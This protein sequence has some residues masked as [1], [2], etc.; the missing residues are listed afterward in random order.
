MQLAHL[1][2][3]S[4]GAPSP[5]KD[6]SPM[7]PLLL[8]LLPVL[9]MTAALLCLPA[10][11]RGL[12]D[13][14]HTVW[15]HQDG[16]PSDIHGLAQ[17]TDGWLW[18]GG[19]DGLFRF[20]GVGFERYAPAGH[21]A[22]VHMPVIE[23][24]AADNGDLYVAYFPQDVG[25]IRRDG[26]FELLPAP[27][28]FRRTQPLAMVV[29]RDG[30]LWTIGA[31]VRRYANGQWTTLDAS[32]P[33]MHDAFYSMLLDQEGRLW[34]AG[35]DGAY[36][37]DRARGRFE[38]VSALH[39]GLAIR[40][41]GDVWLLGAYGGPSVRLAEAGAVKARP[42]RIGAVVSR[43]AGQF[44][45]DG[46]LWA[47][48]CP[49]KIC[50]VHDMVRHPAA[51]HATRD[52]D[53]RIPS[54]DGMAGQE[55][56]GILE[57]REG[58]IWVHAQNGLNQFR[59]KRFL[60][61]SPRL[62]LTDHF[63]SMAPDGAGNVWIAERI[64]GKLWR[65]GA[66]GVPVATP[67]APVR[68]LAS[69]RDGTLLKADGRSITRVLGD[70]VETI[71]LP[72]GPEGKP[73]DRRLLG[74]LDDGKRIWTASTDLG[75]IAWE[76]DR[77][78]RGAEIGLPDRI[79]FSQADGRGRSWLVRYN[80][81]LVFLD[82]GGKRT[83]FDA[84]PVG[85][86][87]G[88][89]PG[90]RP[91][92]GGADGLAVLKDGKLQL[93]RGADAD[94]LRGVSGIA[95]TADG[96]RWLNGIKGVVRV[97]AA[98]WEQA[99]DH[100]EKLLRHELFGT[101]DGYPGRASIL[102]RAPTAHSG[103]GRHVWFISSRGIVGLDSANLR[104]N[105]APPHPVVLDVS[106]DG[107]RFDAARDLR[108]PPG[109]QSF[110]VRFTAPSLRQPENTR[111]EFRLD[112]VDAG[113][114]EAGNRRSTSYTNVAPGDYVFRVRAFNED[115]MQSRE[116]AAVRMTVEPTLVQTWP[117]KLAVA[118]A[119]AALLVVLYRLR[120]RYLTRRILEGVEIRT[121]ER[122]RIARTLHDSFLQ[123]VYLLLLRL[124]KLMARLPDRDDT[125]R[126]L[127]SILDDTGKTLDAGRDEVHALRVARTIEEVVREG[128]AG[129]RLLHPEVG[130][131]LRSEGAPG[132][133]DQELVDEAGAIAC[134]ALR[135]AFTHARARRIVVTIGHGKREL[136]VLVE[137]DGQ[138]MNPQVIGAGG[139]DGHWGLVGMRERAAR[140]GARL[141]VRS[142]AGDGKGTLV[143][144]SVPLP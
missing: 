138:G 12:K 56:L 69:G 39:G 48:A 100:P 89:F 24:H 50:L 68:M 26:R 66:D 80:N 129:L 93:L 34:A 139:R 62:D 49:D 121:A 36:R 53:E 3:D 33:W 81:E 97:R 78:R 13:Y 63:Y 44:A 21:P 35:P 65:M 73:V 58:N 51:L 102:W 74:L 52:A 77:W 92:L 128:A 86:V 72:P 30:S 113:W 82:D 144:L 114:R 7:I 104:R 127:Q 123:S 136:S 16:A 135:N 2:P 32:A 1:E 105:T 141:E 75:P 120:V 15:T 29:D 47:L 118:A 84:G 132:A 79:Y 95:V 60:V 108:L 71:P 54:D 99:L 55:S 46:T 126:E 119:L 27:A 5:R 115:G 6:I 140:I 76:Q 41:D 103:D 28:D 17:T 4:S 94:A 131:A 19:G 96:D 18:V 143:E 40:P 20:D 14:R 70:T 142:G 85:I 111:F 90:R 38:K 134:E 117:F 91:V 112:G 110:R 137:D 107:A 43:V 61:P 133:A 101:A 98:D 45:A 42:A 83:T 116:D 57:D 88:I 125:R 9:W 10:A 124:R 11:A 31:G 23:L 64:S 25:V 67:G 122:E 130:F 8:R 59:P 22:F 106:T 109:S 87:T 37:L